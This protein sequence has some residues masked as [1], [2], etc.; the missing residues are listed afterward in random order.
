MA[1][2]RV[3]KKIAR[4]MPGLDTKLMQAGLKDT[5]ANFIKKTIITASYLTVGLVFS[6]SLVLSK[7]ELGPM[8]A[9]ISAP[10][11]VIMAFFYFLKF[12]DVKILRIEK[13]I[14]GEIVYAGRFL[15]IELESGIP[16][17]ESFRHVA[18][19]YPTIGKYFQ[20]IIEDID[21]GTSMDDAI[22]RAIELTPSKNFRRMLWQILNSMNTG[23]D[24]AKSLNAVVEQ[25]VREQKVE[26]NEYGR[27]LNPLAMFYM[28][29][30]VVLPSI[31]I[32]MFVVFVSFIGVELN[33][34]SLLLIAG[35][36]GFVQFLFYNIVK[37][38]RPA[39]QLE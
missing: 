19:N 32:T 26:L 13:E 24:V 34:T 25:I 20:S 6:V 35:F 30:A 7:T 38:S 5:P 14:D 8:P 33:M 1:V 2:N 17:Y 37:G 31:G 10:F 39:S 9:I 23:A 16:A 29:L 27:K 22:N 11:L 21:F 18:H 4:G 28:I 3:F 15:I 36:M 12:P